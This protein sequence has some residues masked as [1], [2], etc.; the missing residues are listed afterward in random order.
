M[1]WAEVKVKSVVSRH[2][3]RKGEIFMWNGGDPGG[4][5]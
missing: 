3:S 4:S 5:V 2:R 1:S